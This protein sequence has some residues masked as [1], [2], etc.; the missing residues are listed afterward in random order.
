MQLS[1]IAE[2]IEFADQVMTLENLGCKFGQGFY[3][4]RPLDKSQL[5]KIHQIENLTIDYDD[6]NLIY[7]ELTLIF[8]KN[9]H[10]NQTPPISENEK[11][12]AANG[13]DA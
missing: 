1:T 10:Q 12:I 13:Q 9:Q 5:S 3:F 4:A 7:P 6:E 8:N 11:R 2:G